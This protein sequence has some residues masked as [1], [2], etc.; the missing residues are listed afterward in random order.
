MGDFI[1]V[2]GLL[3]IGMW[4][5]WELF[6]VENGSLSPPNL[7]VTDGKKKRKKKSKNKNLESLSLTNGTPN[8]SDSLKAD[9]SVEDIVMEQNETPKK[10]KIKVCVF[11]YING[12]FTIPGQIA[13][14]AMLKNATHTQDFLTYNSYCWMNTYVSYFLK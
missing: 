6:F 3:R 10:K 8:S 5:W 13:K 9:Q 11:L 12:N 2:C 4:M 7:P 1:I 14:S